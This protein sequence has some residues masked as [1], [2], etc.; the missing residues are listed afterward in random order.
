[1]R[2]RDQISWIFQVPV[3]WIIHILSTWFWRRIPKLY[4]LVLFLGCLIRMG[5]FQSKA[6]LLVEY[7]VPF[8]IRSLPLVF[9]NG[10][11]LILHQ[12]VWFST[13]VPLALDTL[14]Y[15]RCSVTWL[16]IYHVMTF[17]N[18]HPPTKDVCNP[19]LGTCFTMTQV[20]ITT[21]LIND[22]YRL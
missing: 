6:L 3:F 12:I 22:G 2:E 9:L 13:S 5:M 18:L 21:R 7:V 10:V 4:D 11:I 1:M 20:V 14:V 8:F 15:L 16:R 19:I 17:I